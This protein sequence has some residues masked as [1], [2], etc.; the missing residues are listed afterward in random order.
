[1][2]N[3]KKNDKPEKVERVVD[4]RRF[5]KTMDGLIEFAVLIEQAS[6]SRRQKILRDTVKEDPDF[7]RSALR[8]VVFFEELVHLDEGILA[9]IL[10]KVSSRLL[11]YSIKK[12]EPG[13]KKHILKH[14]SYVNI[15][16]TLDEEEQIRENIPDE[17][18][19]GAQ[20]QILK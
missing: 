20:R 11:A 9:E 12:S 15:K 2:P 8:K 4:L 19:Q 17:F 16:E 1:M 13:F 5:K 10:S 3:P 7:L 14:L 6:D 18:V